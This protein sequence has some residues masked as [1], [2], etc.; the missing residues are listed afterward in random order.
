MATV[1]A[2][3][4]VTGS[5]AIIARNAKFGTELDHEHIYKIWDPVYK[6]LNMATMRNA[7]FTPDMFNTAY[8]GSGYKQ[9]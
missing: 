1:Q 8:R 9:Y 4:F 6:N 2:F 7:E 3:Y 5:T